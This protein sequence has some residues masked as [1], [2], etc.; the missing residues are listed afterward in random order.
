MPIPRAIPSVSPQY[1]L[2]LARC[3]GLPELAQKRLWQASILHDI[4]KIGIPDAILN[5]KGTAYAE[6]WSIMTSHPVR[7]ETICSN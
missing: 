4:G 3:L 7:G 2:E 5:K 6:E 1:A